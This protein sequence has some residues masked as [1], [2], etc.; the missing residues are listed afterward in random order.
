MFT[1]KTL[2]ELKM[3]QLDFIMDAYTRL[4]VD[5]PEAT[6]RKSNANRIA[7]IRE[8]QSALKA[9]P[10]EVAEDRLDEFE[11]KKVGDIVLVSIDD[12]ADMV[13]EPEEDIK[14]T[15]PAS[16]ETDESK[17]ASKEEDDKQEEEN[18]PAEKTADVFTQLQKLANA[19]KLVYE[20][21]KIVSVRN[22]IAN[23]RRFVDLDA[24]VMTFTAT[25]EQAK[26]LLN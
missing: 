26:A 12:Y 5:A 25:M 3:A 23:G 17:E 14:I 2:P 1:E 22:K 20:G 15:K 11:G 9:V 16:T 4:G 19:G 24:G 18:K 8:A 10:Y 7:Y 21:R 6:D 13:A